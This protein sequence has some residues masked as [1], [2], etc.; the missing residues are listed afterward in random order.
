MS[1]L[2]KTHLNAYR[3]IDGPLKG[4]VF[5]FLDRVGGARPRKLG[6]RT[7]SGNDE[8]VVMQLNLDI[9]RFDPWE[10][11]AGC[12]GLRVR[13]FTKVHSREFARL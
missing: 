9:R 7:S 4:A 6:R 11:K 10:L 5:E 1:Q 13:I 3:Q 2:K 8:L 12:D